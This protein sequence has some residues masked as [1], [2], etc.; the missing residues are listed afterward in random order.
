MLIN[1]CCCNKWWLIIIYSFSKF[2][3][4][5]TNVLL[6]LLGVIL[7]AWISWPFMVSEDC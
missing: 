7:V 3:C 1:C 4:N 5:V 2:C 6:C